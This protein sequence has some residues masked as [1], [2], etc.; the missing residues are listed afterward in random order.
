M[1]VIQTSQVF[2]GETQIEDIKINPKSRDDVD[3][4]LNAY[5][6]ANRSLIPITPS[7]DAP[8]QLQRIINKL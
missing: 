7:S 6:D 5:S 3:H 1:R 2:L 4:L 8:T